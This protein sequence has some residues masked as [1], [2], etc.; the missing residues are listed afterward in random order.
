MSNQIVETHLIDLDKDEISDT[1][2]LKGLNKYTYN[3]KLIDF[4]PGIV[5]ELIIKFSN[6]SKYV[7]DLQFDTIDNV[8]T[9]RFENLVKSNL[10]YI[11]KFKNDNQYV[12][13]NAPSYG[14]SIE[15]MLCLKIDR[16]GVYDTIIP[17]QIYD[18]AEIDKNSNLE[19]VGIENYGDRVLS[20]TNF[21]LIFYFPF[22]VYSIDNVSFFNEKLTLEYQKKLE[23]IFGKFKDKTYLV[24]SPQNDTIAIHHSEEYK[25][26]LQFP[27]VSEKLFKRTDISWREKSDLRLMRNEVFAKYGYIFNSKDLKEY[28]EMAKWYTPRYND[29][30][31]VLKLMTETELKNIEFIKKI[32]KEI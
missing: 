7:N 29:V 23:S 4:D 1:I 31:E 5:Q 6:G 17:L 11:P 2:F 16:T 12:F 30:N 21:R 26:K 19:I 3:G 27:E 10:I 22:K 14:S 8:Y 9:K 24:I 28:F 18:I 13:M 32:E 25:Y 15:E 20:H